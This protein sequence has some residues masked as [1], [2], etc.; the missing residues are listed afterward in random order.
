MELHTGAVGTASL[1]KAMGITQLTVPK[2]AASVPIPH[3]FCEKWQEERR[4]D[5]VLVCD[6]G[7]ETKSDFCSIMR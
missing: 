3:G 4:E 6:Q 5:W 2:Y 1:N 7:K